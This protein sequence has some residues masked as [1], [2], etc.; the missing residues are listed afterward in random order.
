MCMMK[1]PVYLIA[2]KQAGFLCIKTC[3]PQAKPASKNIQA[4]AK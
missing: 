3:S 2:Q 4:A 1:Q